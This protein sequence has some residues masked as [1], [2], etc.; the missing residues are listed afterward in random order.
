MG[1]AVEIMEIIGRIRNFTVLLADPEQEYSA[2]ARQD[3]GRLIPDLSRLIDLA[4]TILPTEI[5]VELSTLA[6]SLSNFIEGIDNGHID[7]EYPV[8]LG[9]RSAKLALLIRSSLGTDEL[10]EE[11]LSLFGS[12]QDFQQLS[13][14]APEHLSTINDDE[15]S[16]EN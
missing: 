2:R 5:F 3:I 13:K 6:S 1:A 10:S 4:A 12:T 8:M 9:G 14:L 11:S 16:T 15:R 7:E